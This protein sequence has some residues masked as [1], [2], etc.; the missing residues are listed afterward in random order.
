MR[1]GRIGVGLVG[2]SPGED[3]AARA[4]VPALRALPAYE[5]VAVANSSLDS[6]RAAAVAFDIPG[7]LGDSAALA[8][9]PAV[10]VVVVTVKVSHR[11]ALVDAA[12][13]AGKM[14]YCEWPLGNGLADAEAMADAAR[15]AGLR[16]VVGLQAR[17][18]PVV[19]CLGDLLRQGYVG[20]V[21][22]TTLVASGGILGPTTW[23]RDAYINVRANGA[24]L[25][26][27]PLG[28]TVD[29]LCL[30]L[31]E[32]RDLSALT[33]MRRRSFRIAETGEE[34][35]MAAEDQIVVGGTLEGGAVAS[36]HSRGGSS[37]GTNLRWEING[38]DGDLEITAPLGH[39]Q[40][41][42]LTLRGA[43]HGE[44]ALVEL[45]IS[46][47]YRTFPSEVSGPAVNVAEVYA[48]RLGRPRPV[49]RRGFRRRSGAA[50]PH[51]SNRDRRDRW[52]S[53]RD[54]TTRIRARLSPNR[55]WRRAGPT[56]AAKE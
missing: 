53:R 26:T 30:C 17:S 44:S 56:A 43:R 29:A 41:S 18:S 2:P 48:V 4:H 55:R 34:R 10:D 11:R 25:L 9:D 14:V 50:P 52:T 51:R 38:T 1:D 21:L 49:P 12:L 42:P 31:G 19:R 47:E 37:R 35:P 40:L 22:S 54:L 6:A 20:E 3:W 7:A 24:T 28:H 13:A 39:L 36:I 16:T 5:L 27:I 32:F 33:A 15:T 45:S 8:G 46:P 23:A